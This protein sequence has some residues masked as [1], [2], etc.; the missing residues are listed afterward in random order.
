MQRVEAHVRDSRLRPAVPSAN[1]LDGLVVTVRDWDVPSDVA[2]HVV[3]MTADRVAVFDLDD[4]GQAVV[5]WLNP[6]LADALDVDDPG[7]LV[8]RRIRDFYLPEAADAVSAHLRAARDSGGPVGYEAVRELAD[9]RQAISATVVPL[10]DGGFLVI[11]RD[12]GE[13][14]VL[15]E[16][17]DRLQE[18]ARIGVYE[19]NVLDDVVTW[20]DETMRIFGSSPAGGRLSL[21]EVIESVHPDDRE[22]VLETI[23]RTV[24]QREAT[25]V[26]FRAVHA[27]GTIRHV[28]G[29]SELAIGPGDRVVRVTGTIQDVTERRELEERERRLREAALRQEQALELNDEVVQGLSRIW[30]ALLMDDESELREALEETTERARGIVDGLLAASTAVGGGLGPG[31][32]VRD[33]AA[34]RDDGIAS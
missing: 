4:E 3:R 26:E 14:Q 22:H 6:A 24:E 13:R 11:G 1:P 25:P 5:R 21:S 12:T 29:T 31:D 17:F 15:R 2:R 19:W 18:L 33:R 20:S 30:L 28:H 8:G 32:L 7:S 9:G 34:G 23:E 27:D 16:R 10:D